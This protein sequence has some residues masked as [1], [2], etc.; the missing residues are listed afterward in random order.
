[1]PRRQGEKFEV[2]ISFRAS[3]RNQPQISFK[4]TE[5]SPDFIPDGAQRKN[6]WISYQRGSKLGLYLRS[7]LQIERL[8]HPF[9]FPSLRTNAA[10]SSEL[11]YSREP[12]RR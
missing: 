4:R 9:L 8:R 6:F 1:M 5:N 11:G 10:A 3:P 12:P 7:H 2:R